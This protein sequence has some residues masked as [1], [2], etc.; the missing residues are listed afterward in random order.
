MVHLLF[1][2]ALRG[3]VVRGPVAGKSHAYALVGD[4]LGGPAPKLPGGDR[5]RA[6]AELAR[7]YLRGHSPATE[8]DLAYWAGLP[9]RD[10]RA[11]LRSIGAELVELGDGLV[12]LA[13]RREVPAG[14]P[15]RLLGVYDPSTVGWP[16]R[17]WMVARAHTR[18]AFSGGVFRALATIDGLAVA[19]W[20]ASR[21][22]NGIAIRMQPFDT[23]SAEV[24][25]ALAAEAG[26]VARF[27]GRELEG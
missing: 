2:T 16:D 21:S 24:E 10:A 5:D 7:R 20:G 27:E 13:G 14:L 17:R 23:L 26:D 11:G 6:L 9:L 22:G 25:E 1:A 15:A 8:R 19:T 4:W 3:L 18:F 12:E